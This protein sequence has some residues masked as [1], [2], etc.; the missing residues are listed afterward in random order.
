MAE[1]LNAPASPLMIDQ[2]PGSGKRLPSGACHPKREPAIRSASRNWEGWLY[3]RKE[4]G[5][6]NRKEN[7]KENWKQPPRGSDWGKMGSLSGVGWI[8][9][10]SRVVSA[11]FEWCP[12]TRS[13][14]LFLP[15]FST[16][17]LPSR[18]TDIQEETPVTPPAEGGMRS[19]GGLGN[20]WGLWV[21]W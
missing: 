18:G 13:P 3:L 9:S 21:V 19:M 14:T 7:R 20:R 16:A 10:S 4:I 6:E 1:S 5:R 15:L 17:V 11:T 12:W 8:W 2:S